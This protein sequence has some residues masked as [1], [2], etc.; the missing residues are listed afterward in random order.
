MVKERKEQCVCV[1]VCTHAQVYVALWLCEEM[2]GEG[3]ER[4]AALLW[5][6]LV[7]SSQH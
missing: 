4:R 1:C 6:V 7:E 3:S 2:E 5:L